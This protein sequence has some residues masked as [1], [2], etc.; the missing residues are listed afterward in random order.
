MKISIALTEP[1]QL[2]RVRPRTLKTISTLEVAMT[3]KTP[4]DGR[5]TIIFDADD[6][7]WFCSRYYRAINK[8]CISIMREYLPIGHECEAVEKRC[9]AIQGHTMK[10]TGFTDRLYE[11]A[12]VETYIHYCHKFKVMNDPV[13]ADRIFEV[14][15]TVRSAE[16]ELFP[17]TREAL[18]ELSRLHDLYVL[19]LGPPDF[20]NS[21][22]DRHD[23]RRYFKAVHATRWPKGPQ[24]RLLSLENPGRT[25]MVGDSQRSDIEPALKLGL[26]AAWL[27]KNMD[28]WLPGHPSIDLN[29]VHS[30]NS[31]AD[32]SNLLD[33]LNC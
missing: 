5:W 30:V 32:I 28:A 12:W 10:R 14:A 20:Q 15:C 9:N 23:L 27:Q 11:D 21:K 7:L 1:G 22:I 16:Y 13:V 2:A 33:R 6:T 19:T 8:L 31:I 25:M 4:R 29:H 17:E 3:S 24:M 26:H 18:R